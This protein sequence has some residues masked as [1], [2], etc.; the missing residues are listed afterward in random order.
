MWT[1]N[2]LRVAW[3]LRWGGADVKVYYLPS[4]L[5]PRWRLPLFERPPRADSEP[6]SDMRRA[7]WPL[8]PVPA[9]FAAARRSAGL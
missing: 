3:S 8:W 1:G 9:A 7:D 6:W 2:A 4:A 5:A